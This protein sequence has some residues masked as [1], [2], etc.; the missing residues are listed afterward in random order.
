VKPVR[1]A[2]AVLLL[3][4]AGG[5]TVSAEVR[6][7]LPPSVKDLSKSGIRLDAPVHLTAD[8]LSYDEDTGIAVAEGNVEL[9]LGN[10]S[11]RAD[12]IRYDSVTGEAD[13]SG[14]V[15][16]GD[17]EQ[18][19]AFDRI[20]INLDSETGRRGRAPLRSKRGC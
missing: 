10:R 11:M 19:F 12:R 8:T 13:L 16:Y 2:A 5:S 4:I 15:R 18:E 14:K 9:A 7:A 1:R 6:L 3:A 17:G 20:T